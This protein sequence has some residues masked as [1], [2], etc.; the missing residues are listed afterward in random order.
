MVEFQ[1]KSLF[2]SFDQAVDFWNFSLLD[3]YHFHIN[4]LINIKL[5]SSDFLVRKTTDS[6]LSGLSRQL[7]GKK[8]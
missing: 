2:C 1:G 5:V 8:L 6:I 4:P 3:I 7:K